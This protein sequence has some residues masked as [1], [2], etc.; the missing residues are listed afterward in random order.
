MLA[1]VRARTWEEVSEPI[2]VVTRWCPG[3]PVRPAGQEPGY[4]VEMTITP[5]QDVER[6]PGE[7][8]AL[9]YHRHISESMLRNAPEIRGVMEVVCRNVGL[10][11][12]EAFANELEALIARETGQ[13]PMTPE[14]RYQ[15][16]RRR[17]DFQYSSAVG[18]AL[19]GV[20]YPEGTATLAERR[21]RLNAPGEMD[22]WRTGMVPANPD[23]CR[24]CHGRIVYAYPQW[25]VDTELPA[26]STDPSICP[27]SPSLSHY[28]E[29]EGST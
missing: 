2:P 22:T 27:R 21:G 5:D 4:T 7:G 18:Q 3:T 24:W 6:A 23:R 8:Q 1:E 9:T 14:E 11:A 20:D 28:H 15:A 26:G 16:D 19:E 25:V 17:A 12:A 13:R 29:P 10:A